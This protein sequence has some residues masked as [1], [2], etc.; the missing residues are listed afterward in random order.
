M[1]Y[2][3]EIVQLILKALLL[4]NPHLTVGQAGRYINELKEVS[5]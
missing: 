2:S 1:R 4:Q 5:L 3:N